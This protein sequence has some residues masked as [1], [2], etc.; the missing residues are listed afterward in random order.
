[1]DFWEEVVQWASIPTDKDKKLKY[2][3][4]QLTG[5][6]LAQEY[7][8]MIQ[9]GLE[10][11]YITNGLALVLLCVPYEDPSMLYYYPCELNM[12]VSQE[13]PEVFQQP[14]TAIARVLCLCLMSF[15]SQIH[16]QVWRN[17]ARS[18]LHIWETSFEYAWLQIPGDELQQAPPDS[19]YMSLEYTV[20][21]YLLSSPLQPTEQGCWVQ[22]HS[23]ANCVPMEMALQCKHMDSSDSDSSP[24][25]QSQKW[26]FSQV[27]LSPP[28]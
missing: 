8:I 5:S 11:S 18:K 4:E 28:S 27:M 15:Q 19:E 26:G 20:S 9:E 24:V 22:T 1:M 6:V 2:N 16:G 12:D 10:Y 21:K 17:A 23:W 25:A 13:N 3:T 7:H 14:R